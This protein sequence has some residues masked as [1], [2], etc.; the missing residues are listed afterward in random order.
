M[1][2]L[3]SITIYVGTLVFSAASLGWVASG[4]E[5]SANKLVD[6]EKLEVKVDGGELFIA[7][8]KISLPGKRP[9]L[10][11][12]LGKPSRVIEK[13][14]ILLVWDELGVVAYERPEDGAVIQVTVSLGKMDLEFWP[15]KMMRGKVTLDGAS[16]TAD[17]TIAAI[18]KAKKGDRLVMDTPVPFIYSIENK[19]ALISIHKVKNG[20][21]DGEGTIADLVFSTKRDKS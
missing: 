4:A 15:K 12:V 3:M 1:R 16:V 9:V 6:P 14:N 10:V 11:E 8:K 17:T 18:N 19:D 2:G 20:Q 13:A 21:Y 5:D 7:G